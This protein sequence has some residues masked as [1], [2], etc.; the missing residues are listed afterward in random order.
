MHHVVLGSK[1]CAKLVHCQSGLSKERQCI[2]WMAH[3]AGSG[4]G[5]EECLGLFMGCQPNGLLY[6]AWCQAV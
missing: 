2:L 4:G 6:L 3:T 5:R 1:G